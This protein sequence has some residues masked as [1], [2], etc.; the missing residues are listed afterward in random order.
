MDADRDQQRLL[1]PGLKLKFL[2][3]RKQHFP[4]P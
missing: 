3:I 4:S 2:V 1:S